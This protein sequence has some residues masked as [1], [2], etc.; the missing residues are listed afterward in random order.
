MGKGFSY[1]Q[2]SRAM[3][4]EHGWVYTRN[5]CIGRARR[6]KME[7]PRRIFIRTTPQ[8]RHRRQGEQ[9]RSKRWA[10]NPSLAQF[11]EKRM[12]QK[13]TRARFLAAGTLATSPACRKHMPRLPEM[14]RHEMRAML[15]QA[16]RNTAALEILS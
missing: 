6:L 14:T 15:T 5:A 13:E 8:E 7:Q 16:I 12:Q 1:S 4:A 9:R 3:A 2:I 10:K 11:Y